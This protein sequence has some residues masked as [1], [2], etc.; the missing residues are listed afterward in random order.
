MLLPRRKKLLRF[1]T[2]VSATVKVRLVDVPEQGISMHQRNRRAIEN[3]RLDGSSVKSA[4]QPSDDGSVHRQFNR[5]RSGD[6]DRAVHRSLLQR[7]RKF[8]QSLFTGWSRGL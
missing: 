3:Q 7:S 2:Y 4:C 1:A 6:F 8:G 5:P